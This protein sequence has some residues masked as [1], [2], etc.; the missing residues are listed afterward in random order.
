MPSEFILNINIIM[1]SS[2]LM[3]LLLS[4]IYSYIEEARDINN[5]RDRERGSHEIICFK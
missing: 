3:N 5:K 4:F 2:E 1:E